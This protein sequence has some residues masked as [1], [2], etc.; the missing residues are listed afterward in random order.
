MP[1][2]SMVVAVRKLEIEF[3]KLHQESISKNKNIMKNMTTLLMSYI[4][5][6]CIPKD[7]VERLVRTRTFIRLN[8]LN[9]KTTEKN[10]TKR[11]EN[12]KNKNL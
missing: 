1:S 10:Y 8:Y 3:Q 12:R 5:D 6:L 9:N 7:A 2:D 11:Q 4:E